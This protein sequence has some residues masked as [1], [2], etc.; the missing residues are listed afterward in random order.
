MSFGQCLA[1]GLIGD[2]WRFNLEFMFEGRVNG[3]VTQ[4]AC[5]MSNLF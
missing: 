5:N 1:H 3:L 4:K 2:G